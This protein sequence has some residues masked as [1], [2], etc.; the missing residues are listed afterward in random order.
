MYTIYKFIDSI[1]QIIIRFIQITIVLLLIGIG[2]NY[3]NKFYKY[4]NKKKILSIVIMTVLA[5][6]LLL[7][8]LYNGA[9]YTDLTLKSTLALLKSNEKAISITFGI[10]IGSYII[11]FFIISIAK[12]LIN[13]KENLDSETKYYL[14]PLYATVVSIVIIILE[15]SFSYI[16]KNE[17]I[18]LVCF[19]LILGPIILGLNGVIYDF[20]LLSNIDEEE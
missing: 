10:L 5:F 1:V 19:G 7:I 14:V 8:Y 13:K 9:P 16:Y 20:L 12:L 18:F 15:L 3:F 17:T 2:L 6:V 11:G 4:S